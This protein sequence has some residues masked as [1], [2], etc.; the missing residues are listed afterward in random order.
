[1]IWLHASHSTS[2]RVY[3]IF[4]S[5]VLH[6]QAHIVVDVLVVML[7]WEVGVRS[8]VGHLWLLDTYGLSTDSI[9]Y[10]TATTTSTEKYQ[11][12]SKYYYCYYC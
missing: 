3:R 8:A 4:L 2:P 10:T 6:S 7:E 1:M 12:Y 9:H 5:S 11:N